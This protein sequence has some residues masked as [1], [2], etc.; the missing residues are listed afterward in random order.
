MSG[1]SARLWTGQT[2]TRIKHATGHCPSKAHDR[3]HLGL[4]GRRVLVS[5]RWTGK[6]PDEHRA[7][8]AVG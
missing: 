7:D 2:Q 5:R 8:R 6:T 3:D 4:G 1:A